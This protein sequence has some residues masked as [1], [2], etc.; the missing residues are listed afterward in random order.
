MFIALVMPS[1]HLILWCP[2]L[3]PSIFPSIWDFSNESSVR[4]RWPKYWSFSF[5]ISPPSEY[6]GLI[7][8]KIDWLDLL[9]VEGTFRSFHQH[10]SSKASIL[11]HSVF[12]TVQLLQPRVPGNKLTQKD[13]ADSG[14][15]FI[16][17]VG[18]RQSLLLAKGPD[19]H[20]WKSFVPY[21]YVSEP[22][23]PNSLRFTKEG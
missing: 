6:S 13:N 14:V 17:L 23:T 12:F 7:S 16:T 2:L 3:V 18:P 8:F 1:S 15:Q 9:V 21:V 11:C 4:I 20:L 10:H 19:Q 22:T 5:S